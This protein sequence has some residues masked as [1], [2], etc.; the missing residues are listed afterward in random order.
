MA[1]ETCVM[2]G[3]ETSVDVSTHVDLR[4]NYVEG[5]GQFCN[6]CYSKGSLTEDYQSPKVERERIET[7]QIPVSIIKE[8]PNDF[9][10]GGKIRSLL[11]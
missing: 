6:A 10:L 1:K 8:T 5:V 9:E 2:C 11:S 3:K 4:V 7:V